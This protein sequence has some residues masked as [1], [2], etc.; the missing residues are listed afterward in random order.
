MKNFTKYTILVCISMY[1]MIS[2]SIGYSWYFTTDNRCDDEI[3]I[4][5]LTSSGG[6][7]PEYVSGRWKGS[8]GSRFYHQDTIAIA[9]D[10]ASSSALEKCKYN[11]LPKTEVPKNTARSTILCWGLL[12]ETSK[13][14]GFRVCACKLKNIPK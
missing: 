8:W 3:R 13:C 1:A 9:I 11:I 14:K 10:R 2:V 6:T 7:F 5:Q 4:T 12:G